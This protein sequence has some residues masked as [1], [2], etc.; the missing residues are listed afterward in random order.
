ML[1]LCI[2]GLHHG[3]L[4]DFNVVPYN[5]IYTVHRP[6]LAHAHYRRSNSP[7][8]P[9]RLCRSLAYA[10]GTG[11]GKAIQCDLHLPRNS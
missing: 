7:D 5:D 11:F 4:A 2:L 3:S 10:A 6:V 8:E 9:S 1:L